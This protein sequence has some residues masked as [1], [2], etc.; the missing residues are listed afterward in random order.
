MKKILALSLGLLSLALQAQ[1]KVTLEGDDWVWYAPETPELTFTVKDSLLNPLDTNITVRITTDTGLP[2]CVISQSVSIAKGDSARLCINPCIATPGFYHIFVEA[3]GQNIVDNAYEQWG[4]QGHKSFYTIGFEPENIVSLPDAQPDFQ[5]FWDKARAEL[6]AVPLQPQVKEIKEKSSPRKKVYSAKVLS[7]DNDTVQ[8][9]YTVPVTR[10]KNA[11][12]PLHVL[13]LGYSS[14]IWDLDVEG[15]EYIEAIVSVRG[16]GQNKPN[17]R[18]GDWVQYGL[19]SPDTY[20][21]RG[22]YL[23]CVRGIDYLCTLPQADTR[24]IFV[25]GGSQGGA[26][27]MAVAALDHRI[28]AAAVYITFM[29]DFP[30]Y[31][32]IV[33]WP[34]EP[35][36]AKQHALGMSNAEMLRVMSYFDIKNLARWIECPVYMAIGLQDPTCPPHTN[37]SG[38]NLVR[39]P[40]QYRIFRDYGHHVNYDIWNPTMWEWFARWRK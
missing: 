8:V 5:A 26:C 4:G 7:I 39:T 6:A 34:A 35:I 32:Q 36:E 22:A 38:Y 33:R 24:N 40:K 29:S 14:D 13:F 16:Q 23:D 1:P 37:F 9:F 19:Q 31:F 17:N 3:G 15:Q 18:Y 25:E 27:S 20:Y 10:D 28:T 2:V 30:D 21:Y 12:F 11:R